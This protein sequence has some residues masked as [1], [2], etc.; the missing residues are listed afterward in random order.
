MA[1]NLGVFTS[2]PLLQGQLLSQEALPPFENLSS[3]AQKCLQ[4]A[5]ST[6]GVVAPLVGH[7]QPVHVDDNL[8]VAKV[9]PLSFTEMRAFLKPAK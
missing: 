2:V 1:L 6:P 8:G 4:F 9:D 5:R 3:A 7:K